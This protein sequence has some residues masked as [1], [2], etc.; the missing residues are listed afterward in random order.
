MIQRHEAERLPLAGEA[1]VV[2]AGGGP[3]GIVAAVAAARQG[4][5]VLLI[6]QF[7]CLGGV[8][9]AG[10]HGHISRFDEGGTGRQIIG[11][12]ADEIARRVVAGG[13]GFRNSYGVWFEIEGLKVVLEQLA[14][15]T[16]VQLL[17]HTFVAESVV[18]EGTLQGVIIQNKGGRQWIR[19]SRVVDGTGDGDVAFHA[20]CPFE[21]GRREDGRCQPATLMFTLGGVD[22]SRVR[23]WRTDWAMSH[24]WAEAQ[25]R[26]DMRPF[27]TALM[28]F[29]WT[30]TRPDQVGVNFT[31]LLH[32]DATRAEDLT[33]ATIEGRKQVL[34]SITVFRKYVPG[35]EQ[36]YLISTPQT[37]GIRES[38]RILGEYVMTE[39]DVKGQVVF[40]DT[41]AFGSFFI[42]IHAIDG[43]GMSSTVWHPP[44]PFKYGI[45]YR[46]LVPRNVENLLVAG[47]CVSC[48]HV[49]MGSLRVMATCMALGEAAGMAAA[50]S[51][52][53]RIPPRR[54]D[55]EIL[56]EHLRREGA[57]V[58]EADIRPAVS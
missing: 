54:L 21:M 3:A 57:I 26:G 49:A 27:Q 36:C 4:A 14:G 55:P 34:E 37:V 46:I 11:G 58:R 51:L 48:T 31:H 41:I 53:R 1:D 43:P 35:M 30:P 15:E 20:G 28:G 42:D 8:A 5:K 19:A 6:E 32:V 44:A 17:Y 9:G 50:L 39:D 40:E 33:R 24:V 16:G 13:W 25:R 52:Q 23:Q 10:G 12:I 2:I 45:P 47:R 18:E 29:W 56:R 38:R 22:W 7:N